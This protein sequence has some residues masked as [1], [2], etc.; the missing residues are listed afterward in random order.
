MS[1]EG[2]CAGDGE[3]GAELGE[4]SVEVEVEVDVAG[5]LEAAI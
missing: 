1:S 4:S 3:E 2:P 5:A